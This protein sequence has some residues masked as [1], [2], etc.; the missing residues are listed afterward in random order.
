MLVINFKI[1]VSSTTLT[2]FIVFN[3]L[4]NKFSAVLKII[5]LPQK[6]K[7]LTLIKSPHVHK[8]AKEHFQ[9]IRYYRLYYVYFSS[10]N[11][12]KSFLLLIPTNFN[13]NLKK[14]N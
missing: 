2:S 5:A 7:R 9:V 8:K 4:I 10:L 1:K 12:L 13:I 11:A 14:I 3:T 6:I